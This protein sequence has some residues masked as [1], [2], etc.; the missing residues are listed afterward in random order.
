MTATIHLDP[1]T[2]SETASRALAEWIVEFEYAHAPTAVQLDARRAFMNTLGTA[3]GGSRIESSQRAIR[4][5]KEQGRTGKCTVLV[6][7]AQLCTSMAVFANGVMANALG[8][9]E[10]HVA[11]S[12]H[13]SQTTVPTVLALAESLDKSGKEVLEALI[14]G[15]EVT[16][17][18]S[19]MQLT[20]E[21]KLDKCH[22]PAVFG[23]IGA[24]AAAAK[25]VGLDRDGTAHALGLAANFAAGLSECSRAGT[26]EYHYL[27]GLVGQHALLAA[28]LAADGAV[29]APLAFEGPGGFYHTFAG[30]PRDELNSFDVAH[31]LRSLL[32]GD[33]ITADLMYKRYPANFFNIPFIDAARE[34]R[35]DRGL[36][37]EDIRTVRLQIS[38][39]ASHSGG[40][41]RPPFTHRGNALAST[42]F[43]VSCMLARGHV[44]PD[45]TVDIDAPDI[46]QMCE[47]VVVTVA[48]E[49]VHGGLMEVV[50]SEDTVSV[51]LAERLGNYRLSDAEV[52][53]IS[54]T[55]SAAV[56]SSAQI[57]ELLTELDELES[58]PS[59][60]RIMELAASPARDLVTNREGKGP[61]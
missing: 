43:G 1:S 41:L 20:P 16:A 21:I 32:Q 55:A 47:R 3:I 57:E 50:T 27:K 5:A 51:D 19:Q 12:T 39:Y 33:W 59:V 7:G 49:D 31:D 22:A 11:S 28:E 24:A 37:A 61:R 14:A 23:T 4:Y 9:E 13:P 54:E 48:P 58:A 36:Q 18:V 2:R 60:R 15:M 40:L 10:T 45:D 25:L 29:A 53:E 30:V 52:R 35:R 6:D 8:Q 26:G 56:F 42:T 38:E 46:V 44:L 17:S 34:I